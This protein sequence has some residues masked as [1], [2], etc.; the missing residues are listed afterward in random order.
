MMYECITVTTHREEDE[1]WMAEGELDG[2]GWDVPGSRPS[3]GSSS[4][5]A[6]VGS[7]PMRIVMSISLHVWELVNIRLWEH[8]K[9]F[10]VVHRV[11]LVF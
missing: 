9:G 11:A 2:M 5:E 8:L 7:S 1:F 6:H 10:S 3:T 4:T